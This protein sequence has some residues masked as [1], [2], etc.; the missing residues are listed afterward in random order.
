MSEKVV[1]RKLADGTV[2]EYRYHRKGGNVLVGSFGALVQEYRRS[3]G[4]LTL[5]E[6]TRR[7]Y[8]RAITEMHLLYPVQ[9]ADIR[10]RHVV[11]YR[12]FKRETPATANK[13]V[14]VLS[15]LMQYAVEMEYRETNPAR[16]VPFLP[17]GTRTRWSDEEVAFALEHF[18]EPLRRAIVLAL[19]TGQR[20][21]DVLAMNWSD[22]DGE[23]ISVTQQKTGAKLWIPCPVAL[24]TE[25]ESWK[26]NR[27]SVAIIASSKGRPY[28]GWSFASL[29]SAE[30]KKHPELTGLVF[31]GLRKTAAAKLAEAGCSPHE[32]A[33]ITGHR[34]LAMLMLYTAEAEQRTRA[35]AAVVKLERQTAGKREA[36]C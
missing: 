26:A 18:P 21:G 32:I 31:H 22:Y 28:K 3:P 17:G 30:V 13:L 29:F 33:A 12:D 11:K 34:S 14:A 9:V 1:R 25:L 35:K 20:Q 23:G 10:R 8:M 15:V 36:S 2:K 16:R 5:G 27:S 19:Y 6:S 24:K 7:G 4:F